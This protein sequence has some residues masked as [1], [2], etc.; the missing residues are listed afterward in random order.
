MAKIKQIDAR[1]ILD[2]RGNPTVEAIVVLNN[3]VVGFASCP[4]GASVGTYE[5][6][7]LRD[8]D[9]ARYL[10]MGVQKALQN[11]REII[12]PKLI[13]MDPA[14]QQEVDSAMIALDGTQNKGKLGANAILPVSMAVARSAAKSSVLPLFLYLRQFIK[15]DNLPIKIPTPLF[16]IINGGKHADNGLD[17]QEFMIIPASSSSYS[18]SLE[19]CSAI[20]HMLKKQLHER[21]LQTLV[22]DEGGF[23]PPLS[24]NTDGLALLKE[25]IEQSKHRF[26]F[27]VFVGLDTAATNFYKDGSYHLKERTTGFSPEE[28]IV[29]YTELNK[30]YRLLYLED[31][32]AEDDWDNWPKLTAAISQDT[33]VV[34]DDLTVTNP[35]RLQMAISKKAINGIIIKPNQI[36]TVIETLAVVEVA[37]AAGLKIVVSHRSGETTDDFIADFAVAVSADYAKFGA[38]ARGERVVKYNRLLQLEKRIATL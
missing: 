16:N 4:S 14:K 20:Y 22:G 6:V 15:H 21:N 11:I 1:E 9:P 35:Y 27:D 12:A 25:A 34:G 19:M 33:L 38:P 5:A 3:D 7:E 28:L 18:Q 17:F 32:L 31:P 37:R 29:F 30:E 8:Q 10:G 13:G 26:G 24:T 36:G 23:A 2:S